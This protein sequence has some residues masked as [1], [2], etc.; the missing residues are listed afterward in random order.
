MLCCRGPLPDGHPQSGVT[1][2]SPD[3]DVAAYAC[4]LSVTPPVQTLR[5]IDGPC[6][7]LDAHRAP[8]EWFAIACM[9][10][11]L[12]VQGD[13][14]AARPHTCHA[15]AAELAKHPAPAL[16]PL[17]PHLKC[18]ERLADAWQHARGKA[19]VLAANYVT[20]SSIYQ[21]LRPQ[22]MACD[23]LVHDMHGRSYR[24]T[25]ATSSTTH[26]FVDG[27]RCAKKRT[28][29]S[30]HLVV[31]P[32]TVRASEYDTI[33]VM[34]GV[35]PSLGRAVCYRCR[36]MIVAVAH[37]PFGYVCGLGSATQQSRLT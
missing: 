10:P 37:S 17:A 15:F 32:S 13:P 9:I 1:Y 30:Q 19:V 27:G 16:P 29:I 18:V 3:A 24:V 36:Y 22:G 20:A 8:D 5:C 7:L 2:F 34:P 25:D 33:I 21:H 4:N 31:S 6:V 26:V 11:Q 28:L 35:P 12:L 23:D 14:C